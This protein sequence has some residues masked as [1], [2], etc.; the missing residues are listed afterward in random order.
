MEVVE[1]LLWKL[2]NCEFVAAKLYGF[3]DISESGTL[4]LLRDLNRVL[5]SLFR[6]CLSPDE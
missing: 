6:S 4:D 1:D 5:M 2:F 3:S